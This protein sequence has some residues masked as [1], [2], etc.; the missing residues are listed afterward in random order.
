MEKAFYVS[1]F[2]HVLLLSLFLLLM[3]Q[4]GEVRSM[5]VVL[6]TPPPVA[7]VGT[8]A[9]ETEALRLRSAA[10]TETHAARET[11]AASAPVPAEKAAV[12]K[13][14]PPRTA[15][16]NKAFR[17]SAPAAPRLIPDPKTPSKKKVDVSP[18]EPGNTDVQRAA[19]AAAAS[20]Q[21]AAPDSAALP[22]TRT[23][24]AS[25]G[26]DADEVRRGGRRTAAEERLFRANFD[27]IRQETF[28]RLYYPKPALREGMEGT[29]VVLFSLSESGEVFA[30]I[31]SQST[32]YEALDA[33]VMRAARS[34]DGLRLSALERRVDIR[35][36]VEFVLPRGRR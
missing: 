28:S 14:V 23:Q 22:D 10:R 6:L 34:L 35:L 9:G 30:V 2:A 11:A 5:S 13:P 3:R 33:V 31:L 1:F 4:Q 15:A 18:A 36:P 20:P 7:R 24:H 12:P 17:P 26:R 21:A 27:R 19:V 8:D 25:A 16:P 32:G 29:A